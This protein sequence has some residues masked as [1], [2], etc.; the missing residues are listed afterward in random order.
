M[1]ECSDCRDQLLELSVHPVDRP[2]PPEIEA[3]LAQCPACRDELSS[4]R[5]SWCDLLPPVVED[6]ERS[7]RIEER[8]AARLETEIRTPVA[9]S[10]RHD[11]APRVSRRLNVMRY[12]LA[13][14]VLAVLITV[15][16]FGP[17]LFYRHVGQ[18]TENERQQVLALAEQMNEI[19]RLESTFAS[20]DVRYVSMMSV[21][22]ESQRTG[23]KGHLVIDLESDE[24]HFLA[25]GLRRLTSQHYVIWLVS[26]GRR[27]LSHSTVTVNER[28]FGLATLALPND[29]SRAA[30]V[31]LTIEDQAWPE[32]PSDRLVMQVELSI[33]AN[34]K[35]RS[36]D[37]R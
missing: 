28:S 10:S 7:R 33:D 13:A 22:L 34:A 12:A 8:L 37:R 16:H 31:L 11:I 36:P 9:P 15:T 32:S 3:H 1:I 5:D 27:V 2:L 19:R 18:L 26:D 25:S 21:D 4:L 35:H 6:H 23:A 17:S 14:S 30:S 20:A 29:P 24:A